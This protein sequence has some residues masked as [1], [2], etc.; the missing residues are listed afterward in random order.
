MSKQVRFPPSLFPYRQRLKACSVCILAIL[1]MAI[2]DNFTRGN[3]Q[4]PDE[5]ANRHTGNIQLSECGV[6]QLTP[7]K[8]IQQELG[9]CKTHAYQIALSSGQCLHIIIS[10]TRLG[11][12]VRVI[13]PDL[14][15]VRELI[16]RRF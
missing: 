14:N 8:T 13:S 15:K 9:K 3:A 12:R 16:T 7:G 4:N 5:S 1:F 6:Y 11:V 10:E 2:P